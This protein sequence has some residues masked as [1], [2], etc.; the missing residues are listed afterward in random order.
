MTVY[1]DR[2]NSLRKGDVFGRLTVIEVDHSITRADGAAGVRVMRCQC[3]CGN[4][5]LVRTPNLKS[6]NTK[7]CGCFH[8]DQ[9]IKS[10]KNREIG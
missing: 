2:K 4:T 9:T 10:N 1:K 3:E 8:S 7:S 6:G 5:V